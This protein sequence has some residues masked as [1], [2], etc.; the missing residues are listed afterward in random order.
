[1]VLIGAGGHGKVVLDAALLAGINVELI[2]DHKPVA[3]ELFG[4]RVCRPSADWREVAPGTEFIVALGDNETRAR[5]Y[6]QL[7]QR[8]AVPRCVLHPRSW[9]SP[10]AA[11]GGGVFVAAMAAV[12]PGAEIGDDCI[13]NTSCS[14]D[15]DCQIGRHTHLCPGVRLAGGVK[16][17]EY[18][19]IGTGAC[20]LPGVR[21]GDHVLVGAGAV[22]TR[23]VPD[24]I[25]VVG[26]PARG[27]NMVHDTGTRPEAACPRE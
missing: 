6:T 21:I 2:F 23:D 14:V 22:V 11:L 24:G 1:M 3:E 18:T 4:I 12:N 26:V 17:G 25:T 16:V 20:V 9:V 5:I 19:T 27:I 10:R 8:S 15:H 7:L 13:L